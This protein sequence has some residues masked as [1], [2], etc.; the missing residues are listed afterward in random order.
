MLES[1]HLQNFRC[2]TDR[3]FTCAPTT[4][5]TGA[6]GSGKTAVLEAISMLSLTTSWRTE[7]DSEVVQW[8]SPFCRVTGGEMELV[9]QTHPYLKRLKVDG[10]S[11]RTYQVIGRMPTVLFQPDDV[12]I[13]G[14]APSIR[15]NYIDRTISQ[16]SPLYT[17][18]IM[19]LQPVLKQRNRLL[20]QINE[21]EA[22]AAELPF[23]DGELSR[24]HE[25]IQPE[26]EKFIA[27]LNGRVPELFLEMVPDSGLV[28]LEYLHSP[29]HPEGSFVEHVVRNRYKEVA[30][31]V[32]L[33]GPHREDI[34]L[35][36]GEHPVSESMSRGQSRAL[37]VACKV[38]ELEYIAE[39]ADERPI[40]LLD[41]I[42]SELDSLR[43][44]RLFKVLGEYQTI[45]TTNEIGE[46]R[47]QLKTDTS[48][49]DV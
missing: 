23:W 26:R 43:R 15:R 33:Y 49:V 35:F 37:L 17:R 47:S 11:Q 34:A 48:I 5:L 40:L 10:V 24:L 39:N 2:W 30:A 32:S 44:E 46:L 1:I 14:G 9:V 12:A 16:T 42:F 3:V 7:R 18:A 22:G 36:W 29:K 13:L 25:V 19:E 20:K 27:F 41:D 21:G 45:M 8:N 38:A 31:G 6:N 28:R 4:I